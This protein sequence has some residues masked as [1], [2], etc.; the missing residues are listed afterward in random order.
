MTESHTSQTNR[1]YIEFAVSAFSFF[2]YYDLLIFDFIIG[3]EVRKRKSRFGNWFILKS[4]NR[5]H[6]DF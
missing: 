1:V 4:I 3:V 2:H 6:S 5:H